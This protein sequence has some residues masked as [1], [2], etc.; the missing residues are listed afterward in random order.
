MGKIKRIIII[1]LLTSIV[2]CML[3]V[4]SY[5]SIDTEYEDNKNLRFSVDDIDSQKIKE[6]YDPDNTEI[7]NRYNLKEELKS[8]YNIQIPIANQGDSGMCDAFA[9]VKSAET[10]YALK[11]GKYIDLSEEYIDY[12]MSHYFYDES[13]EIKEATASDEVLTILETYGAPTEEEIPFESVTEDNLDDIENA[14]SALM[15]KSTVLLPSLQFV[16][17]QELK[18]KWIDIL[19]IH[20]MKYGSINSPICSPEGNV[21]NDDTYSQYYKSGITEENSGHAISIVGWDDNYSKSNFNFEPEHDGAFICLNSWGEEWGKDGYYYI[22]YDD[23]NITVQLSGVLET[24]KSE[25]YNEYT[26]AKRLFGSSGFVPS[27]QD[28]T[29]TFFGMKFNTES[30]N[31]YLTHITIGAGMFYQD[32]FSSKAK[33][34]INP[35]DDSFDKSKMILLETTNSIT[36]GLNMNVTL[37]K[38]IKIKGHKFSLVIEFTTDDLD[39]LHFTLSKDLNGEIIAGHLYSA[40]SFEDKE[41]R[42]EMGEFPVTVFTQTKNVENVV[43]DETINKIEE[44]KEEVLISSEEIKFNLIKNNKVEEKT[45]K[46]Y[47]ENIVKETNNE[48]KVSQ[49]QRVKDS[50]VA[51]KSIPQTG[52]KSTLLIIGAVL[53]IMIS[54]YIM[55]RKNIF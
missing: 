1:C 53:I 34:Y 18:S 7:P 23:D 2:L 48:I 4:T 43:N 50:T 45:I 26:Y 15:V 42:L 27:R 38:P 36:L 22:S 25:K 12:M 33:I 20:I 52:E 44:N 32:D 6:L 47:E 55:Y 28:P 14:N 46:S 17:D 49:E 35:E 8:K 11:N 5:A 39:K 31:E 9:I 51:S 16:E 40:Y 37:D 24:K 13:R 29:T 19:K 21:Y 30:E 54:S 3:N 10:N 41:W